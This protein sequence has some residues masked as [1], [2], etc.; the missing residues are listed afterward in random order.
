[1]KKNLMVNCKAC[2]KE[3]AKGVK[4]CVHC[5]KDQRN[6]FM[7]H[8]I[9]SGIIIL[10]LISAIGAALGGGD[11]EDN[12]ITK[13]DSSEISQVEDVKEE[14]VPEIMLSAPELV[15]AYENNEVKADKEYGGKVVEISGE[16]RDIS[17]MLG[18]TFVILSSGQ[19][20]SLSDVQCF[21]DDEAEISKIENLSKGQQLT[22]IGTVDGK[23][24]NIGIND[25]IIK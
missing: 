23:S 20:F 25:C 9:L 7:K 19:D 16:I 21:F 14:L 4:K 1:M 8:K 12:T 24:I 5:G 3:I 17:I 6:F 2:G 11:N 22:V 18:K 13:A 10:F 15:N